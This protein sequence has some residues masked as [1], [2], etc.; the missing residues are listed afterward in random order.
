MHIKLLIASIVAMAACATGASA[1]DLGAN[2]G[3]YKDDTVGYT[4]AP[5]NWTGFRAMA[6]LGLNV[7]SGDA[8]DRGVI[9][10]I[11]LGYSYQFPNSPMVVAAYGEANYGD[12]EK[13]VGFG[14]GLEL[15]AT[16]GNAKPYA[17][18][19]Y[20]HINDVDGIAYGG[21][22]DFM[23]SHRWVAGVQWRRVEWDVPGDLAEDR[24]T[25]RVGYKF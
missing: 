8:S 4:G 25:T 2:G 9:G 19:G 13:K 11:D 12:V 20:E 10:N 24:V 6:G 21:G 18:L 1:A 15:G 16:F 7:F 22:V 17:L 23:L 3:P 5:S 14:G